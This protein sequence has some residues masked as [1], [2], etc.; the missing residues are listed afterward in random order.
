MTG[1]K[2]LFNRLFKRD[3]LSKWR[4]GSFIGLKQEVNK[5]EAVMNKEIK[6]CDD[7]IERTI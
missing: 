3:Y 2:R 4:E 7:F 6:L 5:A 1:M